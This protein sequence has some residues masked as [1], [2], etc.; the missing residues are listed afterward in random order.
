MND[1]TVKNRI[2][3]GTD[4]LM[5]RHTWREDDYIKFFLKYLNSKLQVI[6]FQNPLNFLF[7]EKKLPQ[8]IVDF[9]QAN[10][11]SFPEGIFD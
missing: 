1:N 4:W 10:N 3:F 8:R 11:I 5:T 2:I 7:S 6:A 9:F